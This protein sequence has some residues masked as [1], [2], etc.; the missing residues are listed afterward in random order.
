MK[1]FRRIALIIGFCAGAATNVAWAE[2][3]QFVGRWHWDRSHSTLPPEEPAPDD[4]T[5]DI[6]RADR[7][8]L[9]W[10]L[11]VLSSPDDG[12]HTET[13]DASADGEF[14][15]I[16]R[17]TT[18]SVRLNG[19]MLQMTFKGPK[20]QL[21]AMTCTLSTNSKT[22]TCSGATSGSARPTIR[23]VDVYDKM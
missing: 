11:I 10:S 2:S 18:A 22:M 3:S 20:G 21:D 16:N 12:P 1:Q 14:R 15:P 19:G 6:S 5:I 13:F 8:H 7:S 9:S 17:D 23:Y 4:V